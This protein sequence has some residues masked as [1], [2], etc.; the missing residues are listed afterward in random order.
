MA[1]VW[2]LGLPQ[3]QLIAT[4]DARQPAT[5]R[6]RTDGGP[7]KVRKRFT[8]TGRDVT[9]NLVF[10]NAERQTFDTFFVTTLGEGALSFEWKDPV[11]DNVVNMRF[12]EAPVFR[13]TLGVRPGQTAG[14]IWMATAKLEV[15]P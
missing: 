9:T 14:R 7:A 10:D 4:R 13:S 2:P 8:S 3:E 15:L 6:T 11:T 5:V 12:I 1:L